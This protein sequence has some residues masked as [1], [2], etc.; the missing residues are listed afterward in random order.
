MK[1]IKKKQFIIILAI[2]ICTALT[3]SSAYADHARSE[4]VRGFTGTTNVSGIAEF[5]GVRVG[6][7]NNPSIPLIDIPD[8]DIQDTNVSRE[9]QT[10]QTGAFNWN[11]I[12]IVLAA[13]GALLMIAGLILWRSNMKG[14]KESSIEG[15]SD[16]RPSWSERHKQSD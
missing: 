6:V 16:I 11:V 14:K 4:E 5:D 15:S 10:P 7:Y 8:T 1:I 2:V 3:M 13:L 9:G 12:I